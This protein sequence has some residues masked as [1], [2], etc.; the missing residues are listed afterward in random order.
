MNLQKKAYAGNPWRGVLEQ[1]GNPFHHL[2]GLLCAAHLLP[3]DGRRRDDEVRQL[4][5]ADLHSDRV[6]RRHWF[7][8]SAGG[9]GLWHERGT[10]LAHLQRS[11]FHTVADLRGHSSP[12]TSQGHRRF[13]ARRDPHSAGI[14]MAGGYAVDSECLRPAV[15][16]VAAALC[17]GVDNRVDHGDGGF[18]VCSRDNF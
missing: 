5:R 6:H 10:G 3:A 1:S 4:L 17:H 11:D 14:P 7:H 9:A 8:H 16:A 18:F 2:R 12:P 15:A 13:D